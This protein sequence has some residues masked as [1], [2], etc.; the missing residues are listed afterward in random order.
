MKERL[1]APGT[2][3]EEP[4]G[5][6]VPPAQAVSGKGMGSG[7]CTQCKAK[8]LERGPLNHPGRTAS[9]CPAP[10]LEEVPA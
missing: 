3:K 6:A 2:C 5:G 10:S 8:E 7:N 1:E 4:L 9:H